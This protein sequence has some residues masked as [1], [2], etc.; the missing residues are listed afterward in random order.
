MKHL[1]T[2]SSRQLGT[3]VYNSYIFYSFADMII[4]KRVRDKLTCSNGLS[5]SKSLWGSCAREMETRRL[6]R[7]TSHKSSRD[8]LFLRPFRYLWRG[9]AG[10]KRFIM[11]K[12]FSLGDQEAWAP[13]ALIL[14][15]VLRSTPTPLWFNWIT[16]A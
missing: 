10:S 9:G 16:R 13:S 8:N 1:A 2:C 3:V 6:T 4:W 11:F 7:Y 14:R 12:R 15:G 5:C